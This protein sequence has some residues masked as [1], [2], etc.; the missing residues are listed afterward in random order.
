MPRRFA[1]LAFCALMPLLPVT[2]PSAANAGSKSMLTTIAEQSGYRRTGRYDEVERLCAAFQQAWPAQVRCFEFGRSPEGRRMLALA[3]STDG[4]LD[5]AAARSK[6]RPVVLMQG[7]IHSGEIDGKD[8][9][10]AFAVSIRS[11]RRS[12]YA[13]RVIGS[14][15]QSRCERL[16]QSRKQSCSSRSAATLR[17]Q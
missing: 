5:A 4:T 8:A 2:A 10:L 7:G 12:L 1:L 14:W 3:A 15:L 16:M 13:T 11:A 9:G 6:Q 17:L